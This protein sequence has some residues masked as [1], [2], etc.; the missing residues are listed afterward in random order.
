[1]KAK[2]RPYICKDITPDL[3][4][5]KRFCCNKCF[6][7]GISANNIVFFLKKGNKF[8]LFAYYLIACFKECLLALRYFHKFGNVGLLGKYISNIEIF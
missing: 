4:N 2:G 8:P 7:L 3:Q 1:M 5:E 6:N